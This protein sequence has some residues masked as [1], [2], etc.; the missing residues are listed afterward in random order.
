[1]DA[2][3]FVRDS[4]A[5][6]GGRGYSHSYWFPVISLV[7]PTEADSIFGRWSS[8][9]EFSWRGLKEINDFLPKTLKTCT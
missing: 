2:G 6:G 8:S 5:G 1:M 3:T 9:I 7:N 4:L